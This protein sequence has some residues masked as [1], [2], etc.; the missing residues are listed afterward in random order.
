MSISQK[1]TL[2]RCTTQRKLGLPAVAGEQQSPFAQGKS[3]RKLVWT[4]TEAASRPAIVRARAFASA[5]RNQ[6]RTATGTALL[7]VGSVSVALLAT[8][9]AMWSFANARPIWGAYNLA[10]LMIA[11]GVSVAIRARRGST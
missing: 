6:M 1:T 2:R 4:P 10:I 8:M 5:K 7:L 9:T 11:L 3:A